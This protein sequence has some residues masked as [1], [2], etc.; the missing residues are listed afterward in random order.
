MAPDI[1]TAQDWLIWI[2]GLLLLVPFFTPMLT[3]AVAVWVLRLTPGALMW[4]ILFGV[5]TVPLSWV[6]LYLGGW[7]G[8]SVALLISATL[9]VLF[10]W[11][12]SRARHST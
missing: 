11:W 10:L 5:A 6:L 1:G 2:G 8:W 7:P 4:G 3:S 9:S 12:R